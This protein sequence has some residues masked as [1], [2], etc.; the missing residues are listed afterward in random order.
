M[1]PNQKQ[2]VPAVK[3]SNNSV[4]QVMDIQTSATSQS[5]QIQPVSTS[6][7]Q[8]EQEERKGYY[9]VDESDLKNRD[10]TLPTMGR[11]SLVKRP[12]RT[13]NS[14]TINQI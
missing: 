4:M 1:K 8:E 11:E 3:F 10:M 5:G 12:P 13:L 14:D 7:G 9:Q 6:F 2:L